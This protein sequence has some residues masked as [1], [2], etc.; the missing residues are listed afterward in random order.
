MFGV[1]SAPLVGAA[2][3]IE[4]RH[5]KAVRLEPRGGIASGAVILLEGDDYGGRAVTL[6]SRLCDTA[7]PGQLLASIDN[8][9]P[10]LVRAALPDPPFLEA[11]VQKC[12]SSMHGEA[13][14]ATMTQRFPDRF[15]T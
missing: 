11:P 8:L 7:A 12:R 15:A 10:T 9:D 6:A 14:G 1:D 3:A 13:H 2:P 5:S 4:Q